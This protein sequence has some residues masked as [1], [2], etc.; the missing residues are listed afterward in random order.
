MTVE[1]TMAFEAERERH[2]VI[3]P[4]ARCERRQDCAFSS[5]PCRKWREWFSRRW[6]EVRALY[7]SESVQSAESVSEANK[8]K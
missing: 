5:R 3:S 7:G 2:R 1:E 6:K 8:E 4:C